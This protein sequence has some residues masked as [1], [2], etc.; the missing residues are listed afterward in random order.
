MVYAILYFSS[1]QPDVQIVNES[2]AEVIPFVI[3]GT[4]IWFVI[5]WFSHNAPDQDG[6]RIEATRAD[7]EQAGL[8]PG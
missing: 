5:A 1:R 6:H 7:G 8:Q 3:I 4:S 2:F